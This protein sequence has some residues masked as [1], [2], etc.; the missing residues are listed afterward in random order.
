MPQILELNEII[1]GRTPKPT[2][3]CIKMAVNYLV[4]IL[5][6]AL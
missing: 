5:D 6:L 4:M 3:H 2:Y 1:D